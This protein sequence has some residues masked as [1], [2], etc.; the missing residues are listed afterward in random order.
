MPAIQE[1]LRAIILS[2]IETQK[3]R[4]AMSS[5]L[6]SG[7]VLGESARRCNARQRGLEEALLTQFYELFRTGHLAW[8]YNLS[9]PDPPFFH[10]AEKG[11]AALANHNR[12]PS[13]PGGYF[14]HLAKI[15]T[16]NAIAM[17][18]LREGVDCYGAGFSKAAAVMTGGAAESMLLALRDSCVAK[19]GGQAPK[20]LNNWQIRT[21]ADALYKLLNGRIADFP[22]R[23][24]EDFQAYWLALSHQIRVVRNDA[25]HPSS[26]E[27]VTDDTVHAQLLLFPE[28]ARLVSTLDDWVR[29]NL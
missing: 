12:D 19:L 2:V 29:S 6:Q 25:G 8:G 28:L 7:S 18:Y 5:S 22:H 15:A 27:P 21:V 10:I 23:L 11:L 20:D 4:D 24:K 3:P 13:N 9:N 14:A 1:D 17:S 16:L 26:I